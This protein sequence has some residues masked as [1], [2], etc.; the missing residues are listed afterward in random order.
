LRTTS[1]RPCEASAE[2]GSFGLISARDSR[3]GGLPGAAARFAAL[4]RRPQTHLCCQAASRSARR[5][6][7]SAVQSRCRW[8]PLRARPR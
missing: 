7:F 2:R 6:R 8:A 5:R 1:L 3:N 4:G